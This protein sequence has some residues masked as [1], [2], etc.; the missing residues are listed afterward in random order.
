MAAEKRAASAFGAVRKTAE[1]NQIK[2]IKAMQNMGVS[3]SHFAG[4][5]GYGYGDRGREVLDE[6]YA[7]VFGAEKALVRHQLT[8]GT[9][10]I[11]TCLFGNL[12]PGDEL[13]SITGK[14]YD[15]LDEAIG[16]RGT[17]AGSLKSY[18]VGYREVGMTPEGDFDSNAI[19]EAINKRTRMVFIQR[20]RGYNWRDALTVQRIGEAVDFVKKIS[21]DVI[22]MV[23]NCYGEFVEESEP[24]QAGADLMAGSLIKNPG[25][26]IAPAGGYIAGK[27]ECVQ[28]ASFRHTVPGLGESIGPTLGNSRLMFQGFYLAP[29][30]VA[31]CLKGMVF[32][33]ALMGNEGFDI[34][35]QVEAKRAD[36]IQAVRLNDGERLVAFC[37]G[38]QKG[39]AVDS[40]VEPEPWLMPG[41][42]HQVVMASGSFIQGSSIEI[43]ADGPMTPPYIVYIQGGLVYESVKI[44]CLSALANIAHIVS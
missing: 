16:I 35:P 2:V 34:S 17:G 36:I 15:T 19:R 28:N 44:G 20:S 18:N 11:A 1:F 8:S 33:A 3:E 6:V 42:E 29:H 4:T 43:S 10:A 41:Y 21:H 5:T 26:G 9:Q 40:Y 23:D 14:P 32:C 24:T 30:I 39:S 25:G 22:V 38:I 27:E 31:E 12:K 13:L 37:R 7:A